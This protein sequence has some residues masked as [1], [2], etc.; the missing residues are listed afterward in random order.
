MALLC[1]ALMLLAASTGHAQEALDGSF[2]A[3]A[4]GVPESSVEIDGSLD[5]VIAGDT[6]LFRVGGG[7]VGAYPG[8]VVESGAYVNA[9]LGT[10]DD[11]QADGGPFDCARPSVAC[12]QYELRPATFVE[13][14]GLFLWDLAG[15][16]ERP[17]GS[18]VLRLA[19][20]A[21]DP[22]YPLP[23]D[24][25]PNSPFTRVNKIWVIDYTETG[26][27]IRYFQ[28]DGGQFREFRTDALAGI[29]ADLGFTLVANEALDGVTEWNFHTYLLDGED[30]GGHALRA[31]GDDLLPLTDT[32]VSIEP[33]PPE[34]C[35]P[36]SPVR[37][38]TSVG[39][40]VLEVT[41]TAGSGALTALDVSS[42]A[43]W[44][45][46]PPTPIEIPAGA[47]EFT[48]RI[49]RT[50]PGAV[51][52]PFTVTDACGEWPTFVGGGAGAF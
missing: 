1:S 12:P 27:T 42:G 30:E 19:V 22:R 13:G 50:A 6:E 43:N 33:A 16:V 15:A 37:I 41:V 38:A 52:V 39:D 23:T 14:A 7:E 26:E 5:R 8:I 49:R 36:R 4:L 31:P 9:S 20:L 46:D 2:V 32:T 48:F 24:T 10:F 28:L 18:Q 11:L 45:I 35:A 29:S 3:R 34:P 17:N 44:T 51:A 47:T 40:G 21:Y 25:R